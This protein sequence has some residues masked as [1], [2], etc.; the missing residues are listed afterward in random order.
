MEFQG[1][2]LQLSCFFKS[3]SAMKLKKSIY[4]FNRGTKPD[5]PSTNKTIGKPNKKPEVF[6]LHP[7]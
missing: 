7:M 2:W 5:P 6:Y 1:S 3:F 4:I